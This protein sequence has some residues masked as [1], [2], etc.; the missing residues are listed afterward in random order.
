MNTDEFNKQSNFYDS[1]YEN[2]NMGNKGFPDLKIID[3]KTNPKDKKIL[4][5][6]GG[7]AADLWFLADQNEIT[8][9]DSSE[10]GIKEARKHGI[11]GSVADVTKPLTFPNNHFDIVIL[12]DI[13]EHV[14]DPIKILNEAKRVL[15][16]DGYIVLSL[17]NHFYLPFRLKILFGQNL[18]WKSLLHNHKTDFEEWNYMH[19]RFFT[20]KGVKKMLKKTN[21]KIKKT[22]WDFGTLAHY[23]DPEMYL[24][25]FRMNNKQIKTKRQFIMYKI[26]LP[27][28][29]LFNI[30]FPKPIR[31]K[32]VSISPNLFCAGFYLK[33]KK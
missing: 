32:I 29:K 20:W 30:I 5:L 13:L 19:I 14:Y 2:M 11:E 10:S 23:S 28:Y 27:A 12:K 3:G 8:L 21:L 15:K 18:V 26:L 16:D 24:N 33:L 22:Y 6:G 4:T 9:I 1:G 7:N 25:A 17:P 31:S